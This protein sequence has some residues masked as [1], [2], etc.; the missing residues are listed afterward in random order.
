MTYL[1]MFLHRNASPM[2]KWP[3]IGLILPILK[4]RA[5]YVQMSCLAYHAQPVAE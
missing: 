3:S 2:L 5:S 4:S 1:T